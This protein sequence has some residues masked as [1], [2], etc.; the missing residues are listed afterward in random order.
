[1]TMAQC[2]AAVFPEPQQPIEIRE[3]TIPDVAPGAVLLRTVVSEVC[4]TDVHLHHGQLAGVPYPL[5][6]GH[7][8][9]GRVE[10]TGGQ[11]L[12]ADGQVLSSG[13]T[14]AFYDVIGACGQ[15]Y[16]CAVALRPTRCPH[17]RVYGITL[18]S[19]KPQ[20]G[21]STHIYL[22]P[23][24]RIMKL[25]EDLAAEDYI[26]GGCGLHTGYTAADRA[27]IK[28]GASVL[29]VGS[30]PVGLSAAVFARLAGAEKVLVTGAPEARLAAA[31]QMEADATFDIL[32]S[33]PEDRV[34]W[35]RER[36]HGRGPDIVIE[37]AG[38]PTAVVEAFDMVREGGTVV[39]AG[40]YTDA[41]DMVINPHN[42]I[43]RKNLDIRGCFGFEFRHFYRATRT[44]ASQGR[45]FPWR[46]LITKEYTLDEAAQALQDVE[47]LKVVKAVIRP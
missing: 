38:H 11:V 39:I 17:R 3:I 28:V 40:Q 42:H 19:D 9:V 27:D 44:M 47:Q 29:V 21:W 35:A 14:V 4:G 32:K 43:N 6:P 1:M 16:A 5:I 30:G 26:G 24:T 12:D 33:T 18:P 2:R 7:V 23:G 36:T 41:G 34:A 46:K 20:G 45:R 22:E 25:P 15:C 8:S 13:D 10:E 31:R 37:A